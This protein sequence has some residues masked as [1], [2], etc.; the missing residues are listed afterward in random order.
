MVVEDTFCY[1]IAA[2]GAFDNSETDVIVVG[3]LK[4]ALLKID[5]YQPTIA[6]LD[7]NIKGGK[8]TQVGAVLKKRGIP[9]IYVTGLD[10]VN[11][12][13]HLMGGIIA[14]AIKKEVNDKLVA[15][16]TMKKQTK[17]SE[18]WQE[19]YKILKKK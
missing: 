2:L 1:A 3:N 9:Y 6:L 18:V 17:D 13:G 4:D 8:G 5:E 19:A 16:K 15:V 7:V 11:S 12:T 14:V 10:A